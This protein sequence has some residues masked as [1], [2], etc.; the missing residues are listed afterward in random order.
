MI[1][2]ILAAGRSRR[3][4]PLTKKIPKCL[5]KIN[6]ETILKNQIK[7][8]KKNNIK[9]IIIVA[10]FNYGA[11][12]KE[13]KKNKDVELII[14]NNEHFETTH[15]IESLA[16]AEKFINS[17]FLLLNS[18]I[19]FSHKI[20]EKLIK[21]ENKCAI[22]IDSEAQ[23]E[24]HEMYVNYTKNNR[25][26]AISKKLKKREKFQGKSVQIS[27]ISADCKKMFFKRINEIKNKN[28][29]FY[30]TAAYDVLIKNKK[31]FCMDVKGENWNEIDTVLDY[32]RTKKEWNKND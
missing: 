22:A 27:K 29:V 3:L 21:N 26:L 20:L 9:K 32:K 19:Y 1:G 12:E 16:L 2:V 10:G 14:I 5:L 11:V 23:Y 25:V 17:G 15:P 7:L 28:G 4:L 13:A 6:S 8:L 18:D 31:F 24:P 30:P